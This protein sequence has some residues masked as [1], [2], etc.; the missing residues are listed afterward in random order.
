MTEYPPLSERMRALLSL[1]PPCAGLADIGT[2]HG[3][4]PI[5]AVLSG[6]CA[7]AIAADVR[8]GPLLAAEQNIRQFGAEGKVRT[9]L[10]DGLANPEIRTSL[11]DRAAGRDAVLLIAGMGGR[12][13]QKILAEGGDLSC[14]RAMVLQPQSDPDLVRREVCRAGFRIE[15]ETMLREEGKLY[16]MLRAVPGEMHLT[17]EEAC[18]GPVLLDRADSVLAEHLKQ[19]REVLQ[20]IADSM[21]GAVSE[22]SV[23]QREQLAERLRILGLAEERFLQTTTEV[24]GKGDTMPE[25]ML[26]G[27]KT[28]IDSGETCLTLAAKLNPDEKDPIL[29]AR[30]NG[31]LRELR[32]TL[33]DGDEVSFL[34]FRDFIGFETYRRSCS[35]LF[36]KAVSDLKG[37]ETAGKVVL[38]F[39]IGGGFYYTVDGFEADEE[40]VAAAEER[41]HELVAEDLPFEKM[42]IPTREARRIFREAGM[43]DKESLFR[44]RQSSRT[45]V[46]SL[47]GMMDYYYG[48]MAPS[49][50]VLK[51]FSLTKYGDGLALIMPRRKEPGVIAPLSTQ[52]KYFAAQLDGEAWGEKIGIENIADLNERICEGAMANPIL[53]S[54][55]YHEARIS[56][57]AEMIAKRGDV[58]FVMIAGPSSSG[59]TT[60]SQRLMTQIAVRGIVPHYIGVDNYFVDRDHTPI[61]ENG[62]KDYECLEAIDL[63]VFGKDMTTL[64]EGG[65]IDVPSFNFIEG[66]REYK[67]ETLSLPDK[68]ILVIEGIHC[69]N[70][71]LSYM[72][73]TESKFKISISALTQINIDGHN[74]LPAND[75][76]LLRRM[77]RDMRTRGHSASATIAMWES[78]RRGEEKHIFPFQESADVFF[79]SAL[80]YEIAVI[81]QYAQPILYAIPEDDPTHEEAK[82]LLKVLDYVIGIPAD[83][84][85]TNSI[86]REFIGGGCYHL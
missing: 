60:F 59:K 47:G 10:S 80:A 30:V 2:D 5:A 54:E 69:L 19:Q 77:V 57:I 13:M 29:L 83:L 26:D 8:E 9:I 79:N 25:V 20:G 34:S 53:Q 72:L 18:Y 86:L 41:M 45:N 27:K 50:G 40:F 17:E 55:A 14:F 35:M 61:D 85:P 28:A 12:T 71:K 68:E 33:K 66:K 23:S 82:R 21:T 24:S 81:K 16:V 64:L 73:P 44:F 4:L 15:E 63:E 36:L 11:A 74:R 49:T 32:E 67:G 70:D 58:K 7:F 3:Y 76:R 52:Q 39:S 37:I 22:K 51:Y 75:G 48:Y 38:H 42:S 1:I 84:V 31:Q 56:E 62:N 65:T 43:H 46:Y 78:V 6:R